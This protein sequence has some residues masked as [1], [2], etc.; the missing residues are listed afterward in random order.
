MGSL[1]EIEPLWSA[2]G[3]GNLTFCQF[4]INHLNQV[5]VN[6]PS[7]EGITPLHNAC[8][9]GHLEIVELLIENNADVELIS[10]VAEDELSLETPLMI[11]CSQ[12]HVKVVEYLLSTNIDVNRCSKSGLTPLHIA[13]NRKNEQLICLLL[14]AGAK[15][16][17]SE[18]GDTPLTD[19]A[20]SGYPDIMKL[21]LRNASVREECDAWKL[22][23]TVAVEH[24]QLESALEHWRMAILNKEKV[25][26][27][28][29]LVA[30]IDWTKFVD[31]R[32]RVYGDYSREATSPEEVDKLDGNVEAIYIEA[33]LIRERVLGDNHFK[34]FSFLDL[35][36]LKN[37]V[38]RRC[39]RVCDLWIYLIELLQHH[40]RLKVR[41][42]QQVHTCFEAIIKML[43][44]IFDT[45]PNNDYF[46]DY[47]DECQQQIQIEH[48]IALLNRVVLEVKLFIGPKILPDYHTSLS[49]KLYNK[50]SLVTF[51]LLRFIRRIS[52]IHNNI[53]PILI[54]HELRTKHLACLRELIV[55]V[56][57]L[58]HNL[59]YT[60]CAN[61]QN[62]NWPAADVVFL[63]EQ[64]LIADG[65]TNQRSLW[66]R[67]DGEKGTC[68]SETPLHALLRWPDTNGEGVTSQLVSLALKYDAPLLAKDGN[69]K[70]CFNLLKEI[71]TDNRMQPLPIGRFIRL[72]QIAASKLKESFKAIIVE[73]TPFMQQILPFA[74]LE[75]IKIF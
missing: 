63:I 12:Q 73:D 70:T 27:D 28:G 46:I 2:A 38:D 75:Y 9:Y 24:D 19:A 4:L 18:T 71:L 7:P 10:T 20:L 56:N 58:G 35:Y 60:A 39:G 50:L 65:M 66:R 62:F 23:G 6:E 17:K 33:L 43:T 57:I 47:Q 25:I 68:N 5:N 52:S 53:D 14:N 29:N 41:W 21:L 3:K 59:L 42:D 34:T 13:V 36:A 69:G 48:I 40:E 67:H 37:Y 54:F 1:N 11:A 51:H 74:L 55:L 31:S 8:R 22:L 16:I 26:E 49:S 61:Y 72:K 30:K 15:L 32:K 44:G 45:I 64:L